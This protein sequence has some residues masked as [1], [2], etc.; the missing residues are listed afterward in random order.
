MSDETV[1]NEEQQP[2]ELSP[3]PVMAKAAPPPQEPKSKDEGDPEWLPQRLE[4]AR[5]AMLRDLGMENV[6]DAKM[7]MAELKKRRESELSEIDQLKSRLEELEPKAG[8]RDTLRNLVEAQAVASLGVLTEIQRKAVLDISGEDPASQLKTIE[9]L[10][11][12]WHSAEVEKK[13]ADALS[14]PVPPPANTHQNSQAPKPA[15]GEMTTN[16]LATYES[17]QERNPFA[18]S[19]YYLKHYGAISQAQ[20]ARA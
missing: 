4:Q 13:Q 8:E 9:R 5:R 15:N 1:S 17:L 20:K 12:T 14:A 16:H 2:A 18:A 7:A 6:D 11:P 19:Q 3:V 10:A